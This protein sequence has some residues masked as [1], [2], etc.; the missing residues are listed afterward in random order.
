MLT[1]LA[2]KFWEGFENK[3]PKNAPRK[4]VIIFY[5]SGK[6]DSA[7]KSM[8]KLR[9]RHPSVKVKTVTGNN[10]M[11]VH[12]VTQLPTVLLLKNG[13]EIDR[14]VGDIVASDTIL[15]QL[16]RRATS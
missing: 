7:K 2:G 1:K 6:E 12:N 11:R 16:F 4:H 13:R 14:V 8:D 10:K 5:W 3:P 15:S 9:I